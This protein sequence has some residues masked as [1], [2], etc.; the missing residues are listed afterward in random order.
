MFGDMLDDGMEGIE[1]F[2]FSP[3]DAY[4]IEIVIYI[5]YLLQ[6]I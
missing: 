3:L 5:Q 4:L 6:S 1:L 2:A